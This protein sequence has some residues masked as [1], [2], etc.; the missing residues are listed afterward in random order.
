MA[1]EGFTPTTPVA[2]QR[3]AGFAGDSLMFVDV[4]N[5]TA[6]SQDDTFVRS[7]HRGHRLGVA[8]KLANLAIVAR[9]YP[10][11]QVVHTWTAEVNGPMQGINEMFGFRKV[12][13]MHEY[14]RVD[15]P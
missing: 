2:R 10:D 7:A 3:G 6:V 8:L 15:A 4:H 5:P 14:Q 12:E 1:A 9:D 11:R 13:K